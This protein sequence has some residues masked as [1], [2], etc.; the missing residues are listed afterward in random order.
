MISHETSLGK[1]LVLEK[2][3]LFA[4]T[5]SLIQAAVDAGG[6]EAIIGLTGGSTPKAFYAW[7]A[8]NN[9]LTGAIKSKAVWSTSDERC[10]PLTSDDSNFGHAERGMLGPL[11]VGEDRKFPWPVDLEPEACA[12]EFVRRWTDRFGAERGFDVCFLGMGGDNHTASL[13]PHC[14]LIDENPPE[15]FAATHWPERG[16]RVTITPAGLLRCKQIVVSVTGEG[17]GEALEKAFHG[18]FDPNAKPIQLLRAHAGKT[19]WLLDPAA[20]EGVTFG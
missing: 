3:A 16:W 9:A 19:L 7:A 6:D 13:F 12:A 4:E 10:V 15:H 17:K 8:E 11:G 5:L 14:P 18:D 20:A 1:V 2:T